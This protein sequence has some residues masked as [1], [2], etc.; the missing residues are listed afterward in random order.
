MP[1]SFFLLIHLHSGPS[2]L[3]FVLGAEQVSSVHRKLPFA[4][5]VKMEKCQQHNFT[6]KNLQIL[7]KKDERDYNRDGYTEVAKSILVGKQRNVR[8]H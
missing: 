6:A 5:P 2:V 8:T 7:I 3:L 4:S 1:A